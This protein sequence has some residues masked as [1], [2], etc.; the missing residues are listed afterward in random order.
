MWVLNYFH[1]VRYEYLNQISNSVVRVNA[2]WNSLIWW[3]RTVENIVATDHKSACFGGNPRLLND[4]LLSRH[5]Q[6]HG[7]D[8]RWT[9]DPTEPL[10]RTRTRAF[11][12]EPVAR[13]RA[14]RALLLSAIQFSLDEND[15][16]S[17]SSLEARVSR[18]ALLSTSFCLPKMPANA[19]VF[20]IC[21]CPG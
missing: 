13:P 11:L 21:S 4:W 1:L 12:Q 2:V 15:T 3:A 8:V 17:G 19:C 16:V 20:S 9:T 6:Q 5:K 18:S 7:W 14:I 10:D